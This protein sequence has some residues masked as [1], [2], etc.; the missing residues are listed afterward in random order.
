MAETAAA[1]RLDDDNPWPGLDTYTEAA[2]TWFHGRDAESAE[3]LRLV[4]QSSIVLLYG[5][6]GLGKSSMLQAGVF[7]ELRKLHHLPVYLRLDYTEAA[8]TPPLQQAL[9]RLL[10]EAAASGID[11]QPPEPGEG[12]WAY[13]Q[14]RERPL[15]TTDNFPVTPVLVFDQF[16]EIFSRGGSPAHIKQVL[17]PLAD[18]VGDRLTRELVRNPEAAK[19][20]NLQSQQ[21]RVVLS[22][23]SDF[24]AEV[25]SW[26]RQASLPKHEAL[27]LKAMTR[28]TAIDAVAK[29]GAAVLAPDVASQI[30]DFVLDRDAIGGAGRATEVEPVLLSLCC[31]QLNQRRQ[32]PAKIDSALLRSAGQDILLDFYREALAGMD[33]RVSV[34]IE[35]NLIQGG[36]YRSSFP[37]EEAL[38]SG[39]LTQ[40][41]LDHLTERRLLRIDPQG[42]VP[43]IELIHDRLVGIVRDSKEARRAL[44]Q[45]AEQ[46]EEEARRARLERERERTRDA[47]RV[48]NALLGLVAALLLGGAG[49]AYFWWEARQEA[50]RAD[51]EAQAA[52]D[53]EKSANNS[54]AAAE[55]QRL[56]ALREK[57]LAEDAQREA[58]KQRERAEQQ[59]QLAIAAEQRAQALRLS[60]EG[61]SILAGTRDGSDVQAFQQLLI[62]QQLLP[63]RE[64]ES[65]L[66]DALA[67][68]QHLRRF[69]PVVLNEDAPVVG[70]AVSPDSRW[71]AIGHRDGSVSLR[72]LQNPR[73]PA[74]VVK[75]AHVRPAA[76]ASSPF[77]HSLVFGSDGRTLFTGSGDGTLRRWRTQP[78]APD[79]EAIVAEQGPVYG[80]ALSADGT[81]LASAGRDGS[82]RLWNAAT[83][84][85]LHEPI[86]IPDNKGPVWA[87]GF[88]PRNPHQL[89][90]AAGTRE[91]GGS[92]LGQLDTQTFA[93]GKD[94]YYAHTED[95]TSLAFSP[96]GRFVVSGS[97]DNT[98]RVRDLLRPANDSTASVRIGGHQDDVWAVAVSP[99]SRWVASAGADT[100]VRLWRAGSGDPMGQPLTGHSLN[101]PALTF[102]RDGRWLISGSMDGTVRLWPIALSWS[103]GGHEWTPPPAKSPVVAAAALARGGRLSVLALRND[104]DTDRNTL[105]M[106]RD[107]DQGVGTEADALLKAPAEA[108]AADTKPLVECASTAPGSGSLAEVRAPQLALL[109]TPVA[110]AAT[111]DGSKL[112]TVFGDGS[113]RRWDL[114]NRKPIEPVW[115]VSGCALS[116]VAWSGDG[117]RLGVIDE[118]GHVILL[119]EQGGLVPNGARGKPAVRSI[120]GARTVAL[121]T[122]GTRT[123]VGGVQPVTAGRMAADR[124][125]LVMFRPGQAAETPFTGVFQTVSALGFSADGAHLMSGSRSGQV[126]LWDTRE[127]HPPA[128]LTKPTPAHAGDVAAVT[129]AANGAAFMTI[130]RSG[131][132]RL[133]P[134]QP[135]AWRQLTCEKVGV[136]PSRKAWAE[137]VS[138]ELPF[139]CPC[140]GLPIEAD[141]PGAASGKPEIC[142]AGG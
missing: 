99:D 72:D 54:A 128:P 39:A 28:E 3:M 19:L 76:G 141:S 94:A 67:S 97:R 95:T 41:E 96:R 55:E 33:P 40:A 119:N 51:V 130:G 53:A 142:Q 20:L 32:R 101:V 129:T 82:V 83:G 102:T 106:L 79:G 56:A 75:G 140:P 15:W 58:E 73:A 113:L 80:I 46:R 22:F 47:T 85:S 44:E 112:A 136:N 65:A 64:T 105:L 43:R 27:H 52:R 87:V 110:I 66:F 127:D 139:R 77:V 4:R 26:E 137:Q 69:V 38:G 78:L 8:E 5:K 109:R 100:T 84:E 24:L 115:R 134:T 90:W 42:D 36:R 70:L 57:G 93:I 71:L 86:R 30:V 50:L 12:L 29:A 68:R 21:Y 125:W 37:R 120:P 123:A 103:A 61:Q 18:L 92:F 31:Y 138:S 135:Q 2:K 131:F 104:D 6:S 10:Q 11:A 17:D 122:D 116:A 16:E 91:S 49:M 9:A 45:Q 13:L 1:P 7:P 114:K 117:K 60:V 111:R 118:A 35:D 34:F 59:T 89:L 88:S 98:V 48:R 132:P 107:E 108:P 63:G 25:E 23:R 74:Q 81:Q 133:W 62:S 14:R 126:R 124:P 121:D